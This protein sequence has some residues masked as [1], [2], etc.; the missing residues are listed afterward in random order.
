MQYVS[1]ELI[2]LNTI[3]NAAYGHFW[4]NLHTQM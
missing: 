4:T 3:N 1:Q 2:A